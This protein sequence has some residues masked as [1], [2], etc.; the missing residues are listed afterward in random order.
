MKVEYIAVHCSATPPAMDIGVPEISQWHRD[1]GFKTVGYHVVIRRDGTVEYGRNFGM[2]GAHIK[3]YNDKSLGVCLIG[4]VDSDMEAEDK[5]TDEQ[6]SSLDRVLTALQGLF[7]DAVIQGHT[8][9]PNVHKACPSFNVKA[10]L[11][12]IVEDDRWV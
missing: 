12:Q 8:D 4:G 3:G 5:F 9:F 1:R 2:I 10:W 11:D 6:F 7:P